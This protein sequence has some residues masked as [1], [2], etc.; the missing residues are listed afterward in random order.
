MCE[1]QR[2]A[3]KSTKKSLGRRSD[4]ADP[5]TR[6]ATPYEF[7]FTDGEINYFLFLL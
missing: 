4:T 3:K 1:I 2:E 7:K 6:E 5:K